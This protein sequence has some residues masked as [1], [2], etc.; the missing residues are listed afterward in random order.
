MSKKVEIIF[1]WYDLW[2]GFFWD[3]KKRWLY[4]FPLPTVGFIIKFKNRVIPKDEI[5]KEDCK[6]MEFTTEASIARLTKSDET[7]EVTGYSMDLT[8]HCAECLKPFAFIGAPGGYSPGQPMCSVD[9]LELRI[10]IEPI[11]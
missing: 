6:H 4:I 11:N 9:R 3:Q 5:I 2:I 1:A 8:V 10:P 7:D